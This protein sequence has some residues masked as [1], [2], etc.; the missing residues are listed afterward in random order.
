M[1]VLNN[2]ASF[3]DQIVAAIDSKSPANINYVKARMAIEAAGLARKPKRELKMVVISYLKGEIRHPDPDTTKRGS[4]NQVVFP[5]S[6]VA[7]F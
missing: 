6:T 1:A 2:T 5:D 7:R 3:L 4:T